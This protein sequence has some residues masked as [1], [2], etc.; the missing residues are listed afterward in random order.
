MRYSGPITVTGGPDRIA[1]LR[2]LHNECEVP[3]GVHHDVD[4]PI[5]VTVTLR[6][7]TGTEQH[8]TV[9]LEWWGRGP[10]AVAR[11][12]IADRRVMTGAVWVPASDVRRR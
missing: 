3:A 9:A 2:P 6:W 1:G 11:V 7:A 10:D 8:D 4:H 5:P 12:R